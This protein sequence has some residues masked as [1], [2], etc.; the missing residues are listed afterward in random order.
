M[1][2]SQTSIVCLKSRM[3]ALQEGQ[4]IVIS[5][6]ENYQFV[7]QDKA[8]FFH[9]NDSIDTL[10]PFRYYHKKEDKLQHSNIL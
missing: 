5:E 6:S 2:L 4:F 3:E 7:V 9:W 8:Q 10:Y 1:I